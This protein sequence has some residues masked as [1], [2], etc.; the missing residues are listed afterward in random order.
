MISKGSIMYRETLAC[1]GQGEGLTF[2]VLEGTEETEKMDG[3]S[4]VN[5]PDVVRISWQPCS[6]RGKK[7][8]V[9]TKTGSS[10]GLGLDV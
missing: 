1:S 4:T 2:M 3:T 8:H 6:V 7:G 9:R 5:G 10:R